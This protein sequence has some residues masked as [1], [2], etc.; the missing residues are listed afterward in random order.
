M[1][2]FN[3]TK[4][5][6][7]VS[8]NPS[9]QLSLEYIKNHLCPKCNQNYNVFARNNAY[10]G[11]VPLILK[12]YHTL[13]EECLASSISNRQVTC[14][15]CD[16][17][18]FIDYNENNNLQE[19]FPVNFY[20]LGLINY[21]KPNLKAESALK[22]KPAG[23]KYTEYLRSPSTFT[24]DSTDFFKSTVQE[25]CCQQHCTK[26]ATAHCMECDELYCTLCCETIH[27][28]ARGLKTHKIVS[29]NDFVPTLTAKCTMHK[30]V[31][32]DVFCNTC[33][34]ISCCYCI[35][36]EHTGHN[37]YKL[38]DLNVLGD[39]NLDGLVSKAEEKLKR[40]LLAHKKATEEIENATGIFQIDQVETTIGKCFSHV[41]AKLQLLERKLIDDIQQYKNQNAQTLNTIINDLSLNIRKLNSLINSVK[42]VKAS[43]SNS[44]FDVRAITESLENAL[45]LPCYLIGEPQTLNDIKFVYQDFFKSLEDYFSIDF[46]ENANPFRLVVEN[47]LPDNYNT[48]LSSESMSDLSVVVDS[49]SS[50]S[51]RS[52]S[53]SQ[54]GNSASMHM[55]PTNNAVK[56]NQIEGWIKST[57]NNLPSIGDRENVIVSH[58]D[59]PECFYVQL[60][61]LENAFQDLSLEIQ[62]YSQM[63]GLPVQNIELNKLYIVKYGKNY[64]DAKWYRG[65][66]INIQPSS[67]GY[68]YT[69]FF[70]D[71]G[72]TST[73]N[74][75][76]ILNISG[77]LS[78]YPPFAHKCKLFHVYPV[79][80]TWDSKATLHMAK[81]IN[82]TNVVM[83]IMAQ[84]NGILEVDLLSVSNIQTTSIH[85]ALIFVGLALPHLDSSSETLKSPK[86]KP[87]AKLHTRSEKFRNG[88]TQMVVIC[89][90]A[91]PWSLYVQI[92]DYVHHLES[93]T[94]SMTNYY[95][96]KYDRE[97]IRNNLRNEHIYVPRKGM[98]VAVHFE[99]T[100]SRATVIKVVKGEGI[101][102]VFL[103]D[104]G[105]TVTVDYTKIRKLP[106]RFRNLDCQAIHI[107]L[108]HVKPKLRTWDAKATEF[109]HQFVQLKKVLRLVV[110]NVEK[111]PIVALYECYGTMDICL[112]S[113][114]VEEGLAVSTGDISKSVQ[115]LVG[116]QSTTT[117]EKTYVFD[118]MSTIQCN[119]TNDDNSS[120]SEQE[121]VIRK[122]VKVLSVKSPDEIFVEI[123]DPVVQKMQFE[124]HQSMQEYYGKQR[125][126]IR[127]WKINDP[128]VAYNPTNKQFFRG[129]VLGQKD[130]NFIIMLKDVADEIVVPANN[131]FMLQNQ[132]KQ[133][134]EKAVRCHLAN[135]IPAGDKNKWSGL[136][137]DFLQ[138]LFEKHNKIFMTKNGSIDKIRKS[139]PIVMW[140]SETKHEGPLE[141]TKTVLCNIN[142]LLVKN[143]LAFK[144]KV[145]PVNR[146]MEESHT[147]TSDYKSPTPQFLNRDMHLQELSTLPVTSGQ[148]ERRSVIESLQT[149]N[150]NTT[151]HEN[152]YQICVRRGLEVSDTSVNRDDDILKQENCLEK[153]VNDWLPPVPL[154]SQIFQAIATFVDYNACI[155]IHE[156]SKEL[157]LKSMENKMKNYFANT[158]PEPMDTRW[159]PGQ[160]CTVKYFV[161]DNW[162]RGKIVSIGDDFITVFLID[163]GNE[164][165][166][167]HEDLRLEVMYLNLPAFANKIQ[168]YQ[169]CPKSGTTWLTS[170]LDELHRKLV[171]N[172]IN[173]C[174]KKAG[175][176]RTPDLAV[177]KLNGA[178]INQYMRS[179]SSNLT[180]T[181]SQNWSDD[182]YES[183]E[184]VIIEQMDYG[185][186][187]EP[188]AIDDTYIQNSLPQSLIGKT[189]NVTIVS[190]INFDQFVLEIIMNQNVKETKRLFEEISKDISEKSEQQ[191]L[192]KEFKVGKPCIAKFSEDGKW[193]RGEIVDVKNIDIGMVLIW[194]VDYG[195]SENISTQLIRS[196]HPDWLELP[197]LQ[198]K[199]KLHGVALAD[200]SCLDLV[201]D[202]MTEYCNTDKMAEIVSVNP[203]CVKLFDD[204][205]QLIYQ[206]LIDQQLLI[207]IE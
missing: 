122:P 193:Y 129:I 8:A 192:L 133:F 64:F 37:F 130:E 63:C 17:V 104:Y 87:Y 155:Y 171:E 24:S 178:N 26:V 121:D 41:H 62:R 144:V 30:D 180:T 79:G 165:E 102:T 99:A 11:K 114:L 43:N 108:A 143:G 168:L 66:V 34:K 159:V 162:Y 151:T 136:A 149:M 94:N 107:K 142:K 39:F 132:F 96:K 169:V 187:S 57:Q 167:K 196:V 81:I 199:T 40:L 60:N 103:E 76:S 138:K 22:L 27:K 77:D 123:E 10:V 15:T 44:K 29:V 3:N 204:N 207:K 181:V 71:Y 124:L 73:V 174:I 152:N 88:D 179:Y 112:N 120:E 131:I 154:K 72:N 35:V 157:V 109:L 54:I 91:N 177:V 45:T 195:N 161:N 147:Y 186:D 7:G 139:V 173:V 175:D 4:T 145:E 98:V 20:I 84:N 21:C 65:R 128:C 2:H 141:P 58:I 85:D 116:E 13:C 134:R 33:K 38:S 106:D 101:V 55:T 28:S 200:P 56:S 202:C 51:T 185:N 82:E 176:E 48:S 111:V 135:I 74:S 189:I 137:I 61:R 89:S 16:H 49:F 126:E 69:I 86:S 105:K 75:T 53:C 14:S 31:F 146:I 50:L 32:L 164:E 118:L 97:K 158:S 205:N 36:Q 182:V 9:Y 153:S 23:V 127:S 110:V 67:N 83:I 172:E 156:S 12:C 19:I 198:Y 18:S 206:D 166:C 184:D 150:S 190:I 95:N 170:D 59:T 68:L 194:F 140:Y 100:W 92:A 6:R 47:E 191:P 117:K 52:M 197:I 80:P 90:V 42:N 119:K 25:K 113:A 78:R 5:T 201:L 70:I 93:L 188:N 46:K 125:N 203:L 183:D 160:L 163:Y 148:I 1:Q 115:Y